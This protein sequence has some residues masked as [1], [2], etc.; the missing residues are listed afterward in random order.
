MVQQPLTKYSG[1][2]LATVA[3]TASLMSFGNEQLWEYPQPDRESNFAVQPAYFDQLL[4][5]PNNSSVMASSAG[6][7]FLAKEP[8]TVADSD[9]PIK[10]VMSPNT[11]DII[12]DIQTR[13][14]L[15]WQQLSKALGVSRRTLYLWSKG[16]SVSA[17]HIE[18][19]TK[20]ESLVRRYDAGDPSTTRLALLRSS[21]NGVSA[22]DRFRVER[23]QDNPE[24]TDLPIPVERL[25]T[26]N[27]HDSEATKA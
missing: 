15:T 27:M 7:A 21:V 12:Q 23:D 3:L 26:P 19:L 14:G 2:A 5:G 6:I 16:G 17:M 10:E 22:F 24:I 18:S 13:S 11:A 20:F 25:L 4:F 9:N 1:V 8:E